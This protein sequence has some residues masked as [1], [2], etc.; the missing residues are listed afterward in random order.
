M[1]LSASGLVLWC[2]MDWTRSTVVD[3]DHVLSAYLWA[4]SLSEAEEKGHLGFFKKSILTGGPSALSLLDLLVI[5]WTV[6][7]ISSGLFIVALLLSY[8]DW[9]CFLQGEAIILAWHFGAIGSV[10]LFDTF[11]WR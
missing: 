3:A 2:P 7:P 6:S 8:D 9:F 4:W 11:G 10:L 5:E 1:L